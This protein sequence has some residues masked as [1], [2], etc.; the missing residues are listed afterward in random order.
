MNHQ[1]RPW[2][3]PQLA[4]KVLQVAREIGCAAVEIDLGS[5]TKDGIDFHAA[6]KRQQPHGTAGRKAGG[7]E[8]M[9]ERGTTGVA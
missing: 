2:P 7:D 1:N 8:R 9:V 6:T 5:S 4:V 3:F